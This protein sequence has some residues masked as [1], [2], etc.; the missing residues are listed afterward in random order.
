MGKI[1]LDSSVVLGW[2]LSD[3]KRVGE[4]KE[5]I[6][7]LL[8][9]D[10]IIIAPRLMILE[11]INILCWRRKYGQDVAL[12]LM[13][14]VGHLEIEW[15]DSD[16][17]DEEDIFE[18]TFRDKL[19]PYDAWFL[20]VARQHGCQLLTHDKALLKVDTKVCITPSEFR[21]IF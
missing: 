14:K 8:S 6:D 3:S 11:L 16:D 15:V 18:I 1:A 5:I 9:E 17:L 4:D 20:Q 13:N 7:K 2:L 19:T 10:V 12:A 21:G